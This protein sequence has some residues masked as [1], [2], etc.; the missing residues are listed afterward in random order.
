VQA[1]PAP[2]LASQVPELDALT[3]ELQNP[4]LQMLSSSQVSPFAFG[5]AHVPVLTH[6]VLPAHMSSA[7]SKKDSKFQ[8]EHDSP[9]AR[10]GVQSPLL[11]DPPVPDLQKLAPTQSEFLSHDANA[12]A[13]TEIHRT[14][15]IDLK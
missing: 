15:F 10:S 14:T 12:P 6:F 7:S 3:E 9:T 11:V 13:R 2:T 5:A 4:L 8:E 1:P